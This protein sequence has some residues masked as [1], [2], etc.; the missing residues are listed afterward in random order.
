MP[1]RLLKIVSSSETP[2]R[3]TLQ[4]RGSKPKMDAKDQLFMSHDFL[5]LFYLQCHDT[6]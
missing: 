3:D 2:S 6:S 5:I 1:N 4:K